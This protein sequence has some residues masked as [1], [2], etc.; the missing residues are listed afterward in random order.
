[1]TRSRHPGRWTGHR[2][3]TLL[4]F[5][6]G[7]LGCS[8]E[9]EAYTVTEAAG[10]THAIVQIQQ[11][12]SLDGTRRGD[13]LAGFV[14]LPSMMER[15]TALR[16]AG[17]QEESIPPGQCRQRE[18]QAESSAWLE[19]SAW[20][21]GSRMELLDADSVRLSTPEGP[22]ELAPY[23]VPHVT[24]WLRG[25]V[26]TS[27]DREAENLP[28]QAPYTIFAERIEGRIDWQ[29]T[30][31]SPQFPSEVTLAGQPWAEVQR[32]PWASYIDLTWTP[33][34]STEEDTLTVVLETEGLQWTCSFSDEEG[35]GSIPL[36]RED[37]SPLLSL[38]KEVDLSVHRLRQLSQAG[39]EGLALTEVRFD[40]SILTRLTFTTPDP[41]ESPSPDAP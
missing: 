16:W 20:P 33:D 15:S 12:T 39:P 17:L 10:S 28:A 34:P 2:T 3:S 38:D 32:L 31:P 14:R 19:H 22:H 11:V 26:Y 4:C 24:D 5:A 25:V 36:T 18:R 6:L 35:A 37:G 29:G 7:A 40:F 21:E 23:A 27:R 1:M 9:T 13:A 30:Y 8:V 41:D